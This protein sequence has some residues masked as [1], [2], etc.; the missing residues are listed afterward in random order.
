MLMTED[1][2]PWLSVAIIVVHH[3]S[4]RLPNPGK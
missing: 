2:M 4:S 1:G 3:A